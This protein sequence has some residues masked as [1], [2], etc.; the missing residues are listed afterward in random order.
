MLSLLTAADGP[1]D[2]FI[3]GESQ[4]GEQVSTVSFLFFN[5][6]FFCKILLCIFTSLASA[7]KFNSLGCGVK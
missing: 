1:G 2:R 6:F 5:V 4:A 3:I 7:P